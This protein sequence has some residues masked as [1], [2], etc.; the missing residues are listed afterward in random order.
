MGDSTSWGNLPDRGIGVLPAKNPPDPF[1]MDEVRRLRFIRELAASPA[2]RLRSRWHPTDS[3]GACFAILPRRRAHRCGLTPGLLCIFVVRLVDAQGDRLDE[4]VVA[5]RVDL[6]LPPAG[7][8]RPALGALV[9]SHALKDRALATR[10]QQLESAVRLHR[11]VIAAA[12]ER[13]H[14]LAAIERHCSPPFQPGM[15]DRRV[16]VEAE[17]ERA[18]RR[19]RE[20]ERSERLFALDA[21]PSRQLA[22]QAELALVLV[23]NQ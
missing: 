14:A 2:T 12:I 23:I 7:I 9:S 16:L 8:S 5:L 1:S 18:E 3:F 6:M 22:A 17:R 20:S 10:S 13:E 21:G 19:S 11:Q 15:F 4:S